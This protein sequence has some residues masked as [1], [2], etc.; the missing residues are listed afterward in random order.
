MTESDDRRFM[1]RALRLAARGLYTADPN[2]RVGCVLVKAGEIVGE[3]FHAR[4]GG[5]HAEIN[6]LRDA[7]GEARDATAYVTLEP[8]CHH[9]RTPPCAEALIEA[10]VVRVVA[11]MPDPNPRAGQGLAALRAAGLEVEDGLMA[12][13]A[14]KL[15]PGFISRM[16]RGR[17]WI[18]IKSAVS[19]DGR[20]ALADGQSQ[21]ITGGAARRD[22]QF[23]RA[24]SAALM[25]GSGTVLA[26]D[27]R[28]N[29]RLS[30][31][32]LG[33]EGEVRQPLVVVLDTALQ[34]PLT[35]SL[36]NAGGRCAIFTASE[37]RARI[38]HA[39]AAGAE[40]FE[41]KKSKQGID[42]IAVMDKLVEMEIN[43]VQV[44][45]GPRLVGA[46]LAEGMADELIVYLAP[47]LIG[48]AGQG[49]AYLP[50]VRDMASRVELKIEDIR[51]V[52]DD[53]R[54]TAALAG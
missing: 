37:D 27:P 35:A 33:I 4:R 47:L 18:R 25:T 22:V 30:A 48:D 2:P 24:R 49:L 5:P 54:L 15:N 44:E 34:I 39:R 10:G 21:W 53:V 51:L 42:L 13:Q 32:E 6:A 52:G 29:V 45:A 1:A 9:G 46:L 14:Q 40:V 7:R 19:L 23:W 31:D 26:D 43:E 38:E 16:A 50:G 11:A 17:P 8:C 12:E 3:G 36:L 28:L 41:V 20:T